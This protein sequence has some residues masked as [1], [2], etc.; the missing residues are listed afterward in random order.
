VKLQKCIAKFRHFAD[1]LKYGSRQEIHSEKD[2]FQ[3]LERERERANRNNQPFSLVVF[4]LRFLHPFPSAT[5]DFIKKIT[6]RM[7]KIDEIGWY[8]QRQI[9]ILLPYTNFQGAGIF[10]ESLKNSFGFTMPLVN[11]TIFAYPD[12]NRIK[13]MNVDLRRIA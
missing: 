6:H 2:F 10:V 5:N 3:I 1:A 8:E 11:C 13:N 4:D 9:G 12:D 7:R